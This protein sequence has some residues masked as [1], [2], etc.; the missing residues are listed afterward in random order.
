MIT[1][2]SITITAGAS[3]ARPVILSR[4]VNEPYPPLAELLSAHDVARLA[5]RPRWML[6]GLSWLGR[7]PRKVRFRGKAIG[8]RRSDIVDWVTG[9][10]H[11]IYN[12]PRRSMSAAQPQQASLRP[13]NKTRPARTIRIT[14]RADAAGHPATA[15][16]H[17]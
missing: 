6:T 13:H 1:T 11:S 17:D 9:E 12:A 7:F 8:W 5:R 2:N 4:W 14:R 10:R 3:P 15:N 16:A